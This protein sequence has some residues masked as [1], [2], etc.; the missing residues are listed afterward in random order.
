[1][2]EIEPASNPIQNKKVPLLLSGSF[3]VTLRQFIC[4]DNPANFALLTKAIYFNNLVIGSTPV[5]VIF[6]SL[7]D[8]IQKY[9]QHCLAF[10][11]EKIGSVVELHKNFVSLLAAILGYLPLS[12]VP[13]LFLKNGEVN[14]A[15]VS[16]VRKGQVNLNLKKIKGGM[17]YVPKD[18]H[19][20]KARLKEKAFIER[21]V[22]KDRVLI[23]EILHKAIFCDL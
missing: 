5:C 2:I 18:F 12:Y 22:S 14:D 16:E 20:F 6:V 23:L 1:M 11:L 15:S 13:M 10:V 17:R 19:R 8:A 21:V 4:V 3:V 9:L 7:L